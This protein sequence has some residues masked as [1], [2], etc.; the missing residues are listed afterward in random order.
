MYEIQKSYQSEQ[1]NCADFVSPIYIATSEK[2]Q[3]QHNFWCGPKQ[4]DVVFS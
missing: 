4:I 3:N 1:S 2:V